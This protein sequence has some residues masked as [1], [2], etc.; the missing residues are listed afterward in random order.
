[1]TIPVVDIFAGPGG[2]GEGFS[3]FSTRGGTPFRLA[4]SIEKEQH[5]FATLRLRAFVRSLRDYKRTSVQALY[6]KPWDSL[7]QEYPIHAG[8][9]E[10]E[11]HRLELGPDTAAEA[12]S[13]IDEALGKRKGAWVLVGGP[14]CQAYSLVGRARNKGNRDYVPE[15]DKRQTLYV[16][17]LQILADHAPPI[18]IMENVKGILSARLSENRIFERIQ[19][20]LQRPRQALVR[21]GR[22]GKQNPTYDIRS[23][24]V[25]EPT[26]DG[27]FVV[28]AEQYGVPQARHR[29]ILVGVRTDLRLREV[30]PLRASPTRNVSETIGE[31]PLL[32]S[33]LSRTADDPR[34]WLRVVRGAQ[35]APWFSHV[36]ADVK[37]AIRYAVENA[38]LPRADRGGDL[39]RRNGTIVLNHSTRSHIEADI[40]RYIFASSFA[41]I[42]GRSPTLGDFPA[43]LLPKHDNAREAAK[44]GPFADRFRVQVANKPSSTIT[45]H[46][47][48]D[49]HYYIHYDASQARSLTVREAARLQTFPDDYFFCGP[50]TA[51]YQQVGNAVPPTLA[52]QIARIV[53]EALGN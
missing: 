3:S 19:E 12:K 50:R 21:E 48:K 52:R 32:R 20:D 35:R 23:L 15:A 1:M 10:Q 22:S 11:A 2:L 39:L 8:K 27:D 36:D 31:L 14:P 37:T 30:M 29:V 17:Y 46:I 51:Q 25:R 7:K 34:E 47:S 24:I 43:D 45:S 9:A 13:L 53:W 38:T 33:G 18:F 4:V 42:R 49:G 5:A 26:A 16:E 41:T 44:G 40:E 28:R 6:T